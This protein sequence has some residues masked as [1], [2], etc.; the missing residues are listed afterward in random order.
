MRLEKKQK[1]TTLN[2]LTSVSVSGQF[3]CISA[4]SP[5]L[6][7]QIHP[8]LLMFYSFSGFAEPDCLSWTFP[9][10]NLTLFV[11]SHSNRIMHYNV[12]I[13]HVQMLIKEDT[14]HSPGGLFTTKAS[15]AP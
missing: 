7:M 3:S 9:P 2:Q 1:S 4:P 8:G 5:Y 10:L 14:Q 12:A 11:V 13:R 6:T 15:V